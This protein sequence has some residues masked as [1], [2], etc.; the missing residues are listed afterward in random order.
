MAEWKRISQSH[1]YQDD[2]KSLV[3]AF[4]KP[5]D[6]QNYRATTDSLGIK[7]PTARGI[8]CMYLQKNRV[9]EIVDDEMK[10]FLEEITAHF[11]GMLSL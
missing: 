3:R 11:N 2:K 10:H 5:Q 4:E 9:D 6:H 8:M 7:W 1:I